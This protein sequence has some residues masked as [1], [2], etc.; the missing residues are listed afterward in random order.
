MKME[1]FS[2]YC[3]GGPNSCWADAKQRID[4]EREL[5]TLQ[6]LLSTE[7]LTYDA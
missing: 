6:H 5:A 1:R 3:S 7:S 4:R 2:E